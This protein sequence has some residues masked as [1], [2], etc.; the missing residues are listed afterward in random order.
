MWIKIFLSTC[1]ISFRYSSNATSVVRTFQRERTPPT[2]PERNSVLLN[3]FNTDKKKS[4][5]QTSSHR[6]VATQFSGQ[7]PVHK[8]YATHEEESWTQQD[9][10]ALAAVVQRPRH[11][12]VTSSGEEKDTYE[13]CPSILPRAAH[14]KLVD[15]L[16]LRLSVSNTFFS[17]HEN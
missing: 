1:T 16:A 8:E 14:S 2:V 4:V 10:V 11:L 6:C 9:S 7:W 17:K 3:F 13:M 5:H 12:N 15:W